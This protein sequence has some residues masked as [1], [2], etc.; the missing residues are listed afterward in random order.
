MYINITYIYNI[1][2][3]EIQDT[4]N[5]NPLTEENVMNYNSKLLF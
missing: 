3:K 1:Y 5:R 2:G 4:Y